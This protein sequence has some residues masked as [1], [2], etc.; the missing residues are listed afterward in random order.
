M[1]YIDIAG[2][3]MSDENREELREFAELIYLD[4]RRFHNHV[5][6]PHYDVQDKYWARAVVNGAKKV[7]TKEL[8]RRCVK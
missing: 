8:I 6:H 5:R 1:I 7:S 2:H 3:M 4:R